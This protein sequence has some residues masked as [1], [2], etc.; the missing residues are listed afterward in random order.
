MYWIVI[1]IF[2]IFPLIRIKEIQEIANELH[3]NNAAKP[4]MIMAS[5]I[6][7]LTQIPLKVFGRI[8][9]VKRSRGNNT[10]FLVYINLKT[11]H[12]SGWPLKFCKQDN[13]WL[14]SKKKILKQ[15]QQKA[16]NPHKKPFLKNK[17]MYKWE[18]LKFDVSAT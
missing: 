10:S 6:F 17:N 15:F 16:K 2:E 7:V 14:N 12:F 8:H 1:Y 4:Y 5:Y 3:W 9:P 18:K 13:P 11:D